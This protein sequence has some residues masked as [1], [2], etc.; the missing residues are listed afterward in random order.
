M[1]APSAAGAER[2]TL[3]T[4]TLAESDPEIAAAIQSELGR[5]RDEIELIASENIVS[6]AV[7]EAQGSVLTNKYAEGYPGKRYY[8]G[9]QFVD[10]AEQLAIDRV[11]KLFGCQFA[12]VQPHS[13]ASANA[14]AFFALMQPATPSWGSIP[15]PVAISPTARP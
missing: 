5:Q 14:E 11:T 4:A 8:G 7:L 15:P 1:S 2:A 10:I 9:C 12:N 6:R 3:F 13:G